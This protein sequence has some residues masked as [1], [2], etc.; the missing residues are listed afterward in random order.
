MHIFKIFYIF[1]IAEYQ[2]VGMDFFESAT[3][4]KC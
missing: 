1:F 4:N 3:P 2:I